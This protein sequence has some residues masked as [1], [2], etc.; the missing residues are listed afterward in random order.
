M[1]LTV[2]D[3]ITIACDPECAFDA[4]ADL[5]LPL[6]DPPPR[7]VE[8]LSGESVGPDSAVRVEDEHGDVWIYTFSVFDRPQVLVVDGMASPSVRSAQRMTF[9]PEDAATL[10]ETTVEFNV[11]LVDSAV[12]AGWKATRPQFAQALAVR[13]SGSLRGTA[14]AHDPS[15]VIPERWPR[16]VF[17]YAS[18]VADSPSTSIRLVTYS[19]GGPAQYYPIPTSTIANNTIN[20]IGSNNSPYDAATHGCPNGGPTPQLAAAATLSAGQPRPGTS[21]GRSPPVTHPPSCSTGAFHTRPGSRST[22]HR[23]G[24]IPEHWPNLEHSRLSG[25]SELW[26]SSSAA[27]T[28]T[29]DAGFNR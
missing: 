29:R 13:A 5:R 16:R 17:R 18:E 3:R 4:A 22:S 28:R 8:L 26:A 7:R 25:P 11:I 21:A 12:L 19:G 6:D 24:V 10:V 23:S 9:Q 20:V 14:V 15:G 27:H 1:R 2:R